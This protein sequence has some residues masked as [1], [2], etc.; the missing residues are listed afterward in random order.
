MFAA[1]NKLVHATLIIIATLLFVAVLSVADTV[2]APIALIMAIR[3][4]GLF[5]RTELGQ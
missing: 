1:R 2:F 3:P 5:G 4:Q